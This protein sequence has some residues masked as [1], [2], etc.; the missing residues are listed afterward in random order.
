MFENF[1][2]ALWWGMCTL[3]TI[4]Y[5]DKY[6]TTWLGKAIA[7]ALLIL[8]VTLFMLPA[9]ILGLSIYFVT[10]NSLVFKENFSGHFC[11]E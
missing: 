4:G 8:G 5:G 6:P 9:G 11:S 7:S 3:A 1:G 10:K 2:D